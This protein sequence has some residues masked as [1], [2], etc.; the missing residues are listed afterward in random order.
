[1]KSPEYGKSL[2]CEATSHMTETSIFLHVGSVRPFPQGIQIEPDGAVQLMRLIPGFLAMYPRA[3]IANNLRAIYLLKSMSLYGLRYGGTYSR[4]GIYITSRGEDHGC[5]DLFRSAMMHSEFSSILYRNY[6]FPTGEW[7][8]INESGWKYVGSGRDLLGRPNLY[9]E[10]EDL[11]RS[12][13]ICAYSQASLEED[14]N[15]Y[16]FAVIH[17]WLSL[18]SAAAKHRRVRQKLEVLTRFYE[19]ISHQL[20]TSGDFE[21]LIRLK[22]TTAPP[23]QGPEPPLFVVCQ[24]R[25]DLQGSI[26]GGQPSVRRVEC[27][28]LRGKDKLLRR[29]GRLGGETRVAGGATTWYI[30]DKLGSVED[31]VSTSGTVLDHVTYDSFG[32][33]VTQ[34]NASNAD[35]FLFAGM[36]YDSGTGLY[37]DHARY[38]DSVTGRFVSPDPKGFTRGIRISIG[39]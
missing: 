37:H 1:M 2:V 20:N 15:M 30:T 28:G 18:N 33:I 9:D 27:V 34:T 7:S 4:G 22:S 36:E 23:I 11:L 8:K 26:Q 38:Y 5:N 12:G 13:F 35:R 29:T 32:N 31:F 17:R 21:F 3:L 19:R 16:V 24:G 25:S 39:M 6:G 10:T 14:V